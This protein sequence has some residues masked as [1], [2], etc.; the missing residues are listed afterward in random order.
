MSF[1]AEH[2][3]EWLSHGLRSL[4]ID[5]QQR[6]DTELTRLGADP[7]AIRVIFDKSRHLA[8]RV[9][10][11][12]EVTA[13]ILKT[14][15]LA[16]GGEAALPH[17]VYF[18]LGK[19][20]PAII[21][22]TKHQIKLASKKLAAYGGI[23]KELSDTLMGLMSTLEHPPRTFRHRTGRFDLRKGPL[24]FGILNRT[25]DSFSDGGQ[26]FEEGTA[27][28][29]AADMI[30]DGAHV[31][32]I[33][34]QSTR[35]G[36]ATV[37]LRTEL[38]RTIP[39]ISDLKQKARCVVSI[40]TCRPKV[41]EAAIDAGADI[42]NDVSGFKDRSMRELA[43]R[44]GAGCIIM[45][46]QG[47]PRTMQ[48]EPRYSDLIGEIMEL[49]D[50]RTQ[51]LIKAGVKRDNIAVDPGIGFGKTLEHNLVILDRLSEFRSLGFPVL[52]G[53]SRKSFI[54]TLEETAACERIAG[55]ISS[56]VVAVRN[57]ASMVRVH[58]V[59]EVGRAVRLAHE[60]LTANH[61]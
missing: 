9:D 15:M 1:K 47:T 24:V 60:I 32:D 58:D 20:S 3:K 30:R 49:L 35:P 13:N 25:Q 12:S 8:I 40:D 41:A 22:G 61:S 10:E 26:Y 57:G 36:A 53:T 31:I 23:H 2:P 7:R 4:V 17:D 18:M 6:L 54:G 34:G 44:S 28:K 16:A 43:V 45:H 21:F 52:I 14:E 46:M 42:I 48:K 39:T 5:D 19:R 56:N 11:I 59:K 29:H 27:L 50:Q 51:L 37:S 33:G 55:T 38:E